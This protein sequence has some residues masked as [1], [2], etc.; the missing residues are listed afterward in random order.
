M[1]KER[2][3]LK[4]YDNYPLKEN[5]LMGDE[6]KYTAS[7]HQFK[8]GKVKVSYILYPSTF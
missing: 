2:Q 3:L 1:K 5:K 4:K 6:N 7:Y 8:S